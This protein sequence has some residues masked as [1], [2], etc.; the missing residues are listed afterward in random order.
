MGKLDGKVAIVTGAGRGLGRAYARRLG[1]LGAKVAQKRDRERLPPAPCHN[2]G[3]TECQDTV[4][5]KTYPHVMARPAGTPRRHAP[6]A[7][8]SLARP[9]QT[10]YRPG[11]ARAGTG[12]D[13]GISGP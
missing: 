7:R 12:Q 6:L 10:D 5:D 4:A 3:G 2:V 13:S 11:S 8:P 1:A 9:R